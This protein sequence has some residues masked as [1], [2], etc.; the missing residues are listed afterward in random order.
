MCLNL[1]NLTNDAL[2]FDVKSSCESF[3]LQPEI[4]GWVDMVWC[5]GE[6]DPPHPIHVAQKKCQSSTQ[7]S[8]FNRFYLEKLFLLLFLNWF[9]VNLIFRVIFCV[10]LIVAVRVLNV[11]VPIYNKK[12][13]DS[14]SEESLTQGVL[15][16][17]LY[18]IPLM[19]Q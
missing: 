11:W 14:L 8:A 15:S 2:L 9:N 7:V 6:A 1:R 19:F 18:A 13:V 3:T 5:L 12:I 10:L 16:F 4:K 17:N